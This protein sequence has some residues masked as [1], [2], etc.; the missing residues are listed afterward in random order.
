MLMRTPH[1]RRIVTISSGCSSGACPVY[2]LQDLFVEV[3]DADA[4][5]VES[6]G[7]QFLPILSCH[8]ARMTFDCFFRIFNQF[9]RI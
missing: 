2:G 4:K 7:C 1:E 3:L 9:E 5:P 8:P 6:R